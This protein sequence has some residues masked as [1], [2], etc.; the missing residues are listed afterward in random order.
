MFVNF[1]LLSFVTIYSSDFVVK[2]FLTMFMNY[3][4]HLNQNPLL[5]FLYQQLTQ[6]IP[7]MRTGILK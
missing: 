6:H 7:S 3:V 5:P 4:Y 1:E 2:V